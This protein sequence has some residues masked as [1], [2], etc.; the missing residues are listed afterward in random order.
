MWDIARLAILPS[1]ARVGEVAAAVLAER[2]QWTVAQ[3]AVEQLLG[4]ALMA[5]EVIALFVLEKRVLFNSFGCHHVLR[6]QGRHPRRII[7]YEK[8]TAFQS[9]ANRGQ[10]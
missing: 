8:G 2:V 4:N 10:T 6:F 5:R 9:S 3:H 1:L 7:V